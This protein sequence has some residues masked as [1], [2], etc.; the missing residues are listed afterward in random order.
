MT[1]KSTMTEKSKIL[2]VDDKKENILALELTIIDHGQGLPVEIFTATS[3][4]QALKL[5]LHHDFAL[6]LL[7]VQMP[8]MDGFELAEFLRVKKNTQ[9]IPIIFLSA[10]YSSEYYIMKGFESGAVD[11]LTK[12]INPNILLN[13]IQ[14]FTQLDQQNKVLEQQRQRIE[15]HNRSL[16]QINKKLHDQQCTLKENIESLRVLATV[17]ESGD[18]I[19]ITNA[20]SKIIQVN[21]AFQDITGYSSHEVIGKNPRILNSNRQ[22]N[23]FMEHMWVQ[24][25]KKGSWS[26]EVWDKHKDGHLYPKHMI[27]TAVKNTKGLTTGYVS[28]FSDTTKRNRAEQEIKKLAFYDTLTSLPNRRLL[29][30][31]L[32]VDLLASARCN[33]YGAVLFLDM[34]KFKSLNDTLGH[35]F[36]DLLLIEV[37]NRIKFCVRE[38]DTAAR[39]GGDEF[40]ILI[41][42]IEGTKSAVSHKTA[43]IA[44]KVRS[45]LSAPYLLRGIKYLSSPSIGVSLYHDN[46]VSSFDLLKQADLAMYQAKEAGRNCVRFFD[47]TM[48]LE[49][50]SRAS[51]ENDLALAVLNKQFNLYYQVQLNSE[52]QP[53]GAEALIRWNQPLRGEVSPTDFIPIAE[54]SLLILDI[55]DW[56]LETA[57]QQLQLWSKNE[58]TSHLTLAVNVSVKQFQQANFV[59]KITDILLR[60]NVDASLLK[61]ELTESIMVENISLGIAKMHDLKAIGVSLSLDDF[62]TGYSSL[63]YLNQLPMDQIKIDKSFVRDISSDKHSE[64]MVKAI[65]DI[66]KIFDICVI[67]E[68]V[69]TEAQ[70]SL[71]KQLGC[72]EFQ[73]FYFSKPVPIEQFESLLTC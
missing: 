67:A 8:E 21:A 22:S 28:I 62:G 38:E 60:F 44:E 47:P 61:L 37:A 48:Q 24:V 59:K 15:K 71:L 17:F 49:V 50:E 52:Q 11:F 31:R 58:Q 51:L 68:G 65:I 14:T 69:E 20:D 4:P 40:I 55:G 23:M 73:G 63:S 34:D 19:M 18:G 26:G 66:A 13:K 41:N 16:K 45:S 2:I 27:I 5:T 43:L 29:M 3:G 35:D 10:V 64:M 9:Q 25:L 39:L 54:A 7:D 32:G 57:C 33:H 42:N 30:D 53:I 70:L 56:V 12:P 72:K 46:N 6:I 1:K 36:G